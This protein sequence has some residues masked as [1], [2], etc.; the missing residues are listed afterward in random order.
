MAAALAVG[1]G[2][3]SEGTTSSATSTP[4]TSTAKASAPAASQ[5]PDV[6]VSAKWKDGVTEANRGDKAGKVRLQGTM[7]AANGTVLYLYETEGRNLTLMDST[8]VQNQAFDFGHLIMQCLT[9]CLFSVK[10][11]LELRLQLSLFIQDGLQI[12][13]L[14]CFFF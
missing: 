12:R 6:T 1:C 7:P 4:A 14:F 5:Q 10:V 13:P 11:L 9:T 2:N 8:N 3:A